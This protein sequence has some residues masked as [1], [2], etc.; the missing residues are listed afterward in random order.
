[1]LYLKQLAWSD[2]RE[3]IVEDNNFLGVKL[4]ET[5]RE[6]IPLDIGIDVAS[7]PISIV[8]GEDFIEFGRLH[9]VPPIYLIF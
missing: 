5:A 8:G 4:P 1:L 2:P 7:G 9:D 6:K 3:K